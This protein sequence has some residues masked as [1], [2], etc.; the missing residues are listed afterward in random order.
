MTVPTVSWDDRERGK[1]TRAA[2]PSSALAGRHVNQGSAPG[3]PALR[4]PA[5]LLDRDHEMWDRGSDARPVVRGC[6]AIVRSPRIPVIVD[7]ASVALSPGVE[8]R[9]Q[10]NAGRLHFRSAA[11]SGDGR[12]GVLCLS[13]RP[14]RG[15]ASGLSEGVATRSEPSGS[16]PQDEDQPRAWQPCAATARPSRRAPSPARRSRAGAS[17]RPPAAPPPIRSAGWTA[18]TRAGSSSTR[19]S[20]ATAPRASTAAAASSW[21]NRP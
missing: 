18:P 12:R 2:A 4:C 5:Q 16:G 15:R 19:A 6:R 14:A 21:S 20:S 9:R 7:G 17:T 1:M 3:L 8:R 10:R 11:A 13:S